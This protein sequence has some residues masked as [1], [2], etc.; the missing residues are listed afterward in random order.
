[1]RRMWISQSVWKR[2][3]KASAAKCRVYRGQERPS[4][5]GAGAGRWWSKR[6]VPGP[7]P[8]RPDGALVTSTPEGHS[9]IIP[10]CDAVNIKRYHTVFPPSITIFSPVIYEL[11]SE[12]MKTIAP[13]YSLMSDILPM[14]IMLLNFFTKSSG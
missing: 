4:P 1:M 2:Q 5:A 11:A 6:R 8:A 7:G 10:L 14:G 9:F 13:L 12:H 3:A